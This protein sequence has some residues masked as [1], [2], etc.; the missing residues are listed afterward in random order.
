MGFKNR[1]RTRSDISSKVHLLGF[2]G[3]WTGQGSGRA[4]RPAGPKVPAW[5]SSFFAA[6]LDD[7]WKD[8]CFP[9]FPLFFFP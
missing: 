1:T 8:I 2:W 9:T 3:S 6:S 7:S 5:A 4:R